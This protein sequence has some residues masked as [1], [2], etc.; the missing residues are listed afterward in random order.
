MKKFSNIIG[1]DDAPFLPDHTGPVKVIGA[2]FAGMRLDGVLMGEV[3]KDGD[4]AASALTKLVSE[5]K[6]A[7]HVQLIMLQGIALAGFNVVDV[8]A[9]H[10]ELALPVLIV[11]RHQPD[12]EGVKRAL[13]E[14]VEGGQE[15]WEI[16][17]MLGEMEAAGNIFVQR[18]GL[19]FEE[20]SEVVTR[21]A[22]HGN[23][24]EPIRTAHLIAG[25]LELGQ[26][27]GNP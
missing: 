15:K 9:L 3:Q 19:E 20:A 26:S 17:E 18:V 16:I 25:A 23:I 14:Q 27:H 24:P 1:F 6:F 2:V 12:C 11:S 21:F 5:S 7:E 8:F 13:F 4:D 10:R 22:I